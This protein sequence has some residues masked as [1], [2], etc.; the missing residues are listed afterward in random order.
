MCDVINEISNK[1]I[2]N[3]III[4]TKYKEHVNVTS[5]VVILSLFNTITDE[6]YN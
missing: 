4:S 6:V 2:Q 3:L 5:F 1:I